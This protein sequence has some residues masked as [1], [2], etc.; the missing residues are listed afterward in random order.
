MKKEILYQPLINQPKPLK[1]LGW[2]EAQSYCNFILFKP[3]DEFLKKFKVIE[4][5]LRTESSTDFASH[6]Y[7]LQSSNVLLS[8]KQF[9][10]DWAPPA[11][12]IQ[13]FGET[14]KSRLRN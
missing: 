12:I 11:T 5:S 4:T 7:V 3:Q 1:E 10:Y 8:I 2:E 14:L 13:A 9:L 6:R